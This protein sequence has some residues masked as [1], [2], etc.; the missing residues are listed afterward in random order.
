MQKL[1][2]VFQSLSVINE[3][4]YEVLLIF[5]KKHQFAFFLK[6][7]EYLSESLTNLFFN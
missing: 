7:I 3:F 6:K 2:C 1:S 4:N 5:F